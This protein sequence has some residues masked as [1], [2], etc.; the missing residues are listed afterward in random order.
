MDLNQTYLVDPPPWKCHKVLLTNKVKENN[1]LNV[2]IFC[3]SFFLSEYILFLQLIPSS[4][5]N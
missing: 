3:F 1:K 5:Y 4:S 2:T